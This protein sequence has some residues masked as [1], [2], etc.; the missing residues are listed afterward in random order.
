MESLKLF[1]TTQTQTRKPTTKARCKF[2]H[3]LEDIINFS[4]LLRKEHNEH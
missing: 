3:A 1:H 2:Y 4:P